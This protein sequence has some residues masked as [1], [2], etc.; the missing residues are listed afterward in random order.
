MLTFGGTFRCGARGEAHPFGWQLVDRTRL[1]GWASTTA[2]KGIRR[3]AFG[4]HSL[5]TKKEGIKA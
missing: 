2:R 3:N 1:E 5:R 4:K